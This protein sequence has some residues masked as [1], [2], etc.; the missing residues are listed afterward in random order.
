MSYTITLRTPKQGKEKYWVNYTYN[1]AKMLHH[2]FAQVG[3]K[4]WHTLESKPL[5]EVLPY[6]QGALKHLQDHPEVY[7]PWN[8]SNGWGSYSGWTR[9]MGE[10]IQAMKQYPKTVL[11]IS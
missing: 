7:I 10:I 4:D 8:P 3:I 11:H 5:T 1:I 9:V 6:F 2:S